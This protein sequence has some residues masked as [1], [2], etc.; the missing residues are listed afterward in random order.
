[1]PLKPSESLSALL[2]LFVLIS[3][4][5]AARRPAAAAEPAFRL[6]SVYGEPVLFAPPTPESDPNGSGINVKLEIPTQVA[7]TGTS[8]LAANGPFHIQM[9]ESHP[10]SVQIAL[11]SPERWIGD[12]QGLFDPEGDAVA[13]LYRFLIQL[14]QLQQAGCFGEGDPVIRDFIMQ[15]L[16]VEPRE[17]LFSYYG[18]RP[19]RSGLDLRPGMRLKIQRAY[20]RAARNGEEG[21]ASK[22]SGGVSTVYFDVKSTSDGKIQFGRVGDVRFT[23]RM[24]GRE[25]R[26]TGLETELAGISLELK[27]RLV[28]YTLLVSKEQKLA[29]A[30]LGARTASQLD[31]MD[32]KL[33]LK[34][35]GGCINFAGTR[36][37][38]CLEFKGLVT[39]TGQIRVQLNGKSKFI[40]CGTSLKELVPESALASL[41]IQRKF[42]S[43]YRDVRFKAGDS[44]MLSLALVA[45]DRLMWSQSAPSPR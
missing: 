23:P 9:A 26:N 7:S 15:S 16:P 4:G 44:K 2:L 31:E 41:R 14:D 10:P 33:R 25:F 34:P 43:S 5:C 19:N 18:Y 11:P 12:F 36:G 8:C 29:T 37:I 30:I 6:G 35:G 32:G 42:M 39:V 20:I 3:A 40:D 1:M 13:A 38:A 27:Y 28:F 22:D 24:L 17:S 45:G 21:Q